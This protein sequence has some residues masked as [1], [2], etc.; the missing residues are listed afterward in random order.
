MSGSLNSSSFRRCLTAALVA[1]LVLLAQAQMARAETVNVPVPQSAVIGALN[2]AFASMDVRLDAYG[3]KH[4]SGRYLHWLDEQSRV[5]IPGVGSKKFDLGFIDKK[6][7]ATRRLRAYVNDIDAKAVAASMN[8]GNVRL[9]ALFESGGYEVK[10]KCLRYRLLKKDW[11]DEC[12]IPSLAGKGLD[13]D[14]ALLEAELKPI[15]HEG[16]IS[17]DVKSTDLSANVQAHG[18]CGALDGL[19]DRITNYKKTIRNEVEDRV[20][21]L[22]DRNDLRDMVATRVRQALEAAGIL[23]PDWK[24][25]AVT[26][27]GTNFNVTIQRPDQIGPESVKITGFAA[28]TAS[29]SYSCPVN[30]G[31]D[32]TIWSKY[33]LKGRAWLE[34]ENGTKTAAQNWTMNDGQT[35]TSTIARKFNGSAGSTHPGRWSRLVVEWK[36]QQ[37]KVYTAKSSKAYFSVTCSLAGGNFSPN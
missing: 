4:T 3:K 1:A 9:S 24:I 22:L 15:A 13:V 21:K 17:L 2:T 31:F 12:V 10:I 5:T 32:A 35:V 11:K 20:F 30:V 27:N 8:G 37:G 14:N 36:D 7:T 28:K 16:S 26:T 25:T 33:D 19:C 29:V 23:K 34:N 18:L 6:T